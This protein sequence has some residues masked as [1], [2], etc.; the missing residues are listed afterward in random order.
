MCLTYLH[1]RCNYTYAYAWESSSKLTF[2]WGYEFL[3]VFWPQT[4]S[5]RLTKKKVAA[6]GAVGRVSLYNALFHSI[7]HSTPCSKIWNF[8][9]EIDFTKFSWN[10]FQKNLFSKNLL[11]LHLISTFIALCEAMIS[12]VNFISFTE[13]FDGVCA[14]KHVNYQCDFF[15]FC[16]FH[17]YFKS[18][19]NVLHFIKQHFYSN[20]RWNIKYICIY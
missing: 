9:R 7:T 6:V 3:L 15:F 18:I 11:L 13:W 12:S 5:S 20:D 2:N 8:H 16:S 19:K 4:L 14:L 10:W 17:L 1:I